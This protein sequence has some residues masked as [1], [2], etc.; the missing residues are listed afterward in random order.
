MV[1]IFATNEET[2]ITGAHLGADTKDSSGLSMVI[3]KII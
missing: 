1:I 2:F 3:S